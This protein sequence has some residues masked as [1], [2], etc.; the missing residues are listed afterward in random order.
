MHHWQITL[1]FASCMSVNTELNGGRTAFVFRDATQT[2]G[3]TRARAEDNTQKHTRAHCQWLWD[4]FFLS[5]SLYIS[6][7]HKIEH[8]IKGISHLEL[9]FR[10]FVSHLYANGDSGDIF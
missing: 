2:G 5:Y 8:E 4:S 9:Q 6:R 7:T 3:T 10:S 1:I